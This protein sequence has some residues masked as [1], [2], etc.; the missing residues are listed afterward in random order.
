MWA[1]SVVVARGCYSSLGAGA[2]HCRGFSCCGVWALGHVGFISCVHRLS[3]CGLVALWHVGSFQIRDRTCVSC[4]GEWILYRWATRIAPIVSWYIFCTRSFQLCQHTKGIF[5]HALGHDL[6]WTCMT[7]SLRI[8]DGW[9]YSSSM[10][11][12]R[13]FIK[14]LM[15]VHSRWSSNTYFISIYYGEGV[16]I[17][18]V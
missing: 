8:H 5:L 9:V 3:S 14:H 6:M 12:F 15:L 13:C 10:K 17:R 16:K 11:L 1:L 18:P 7:G 2:S 4:T